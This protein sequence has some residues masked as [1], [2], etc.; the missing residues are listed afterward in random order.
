M[1]LFLLISARLKYGVQHPSLSAEYCDFF[2]SSESLNNI[3]AHSTW[4]YPIQE[5]TCSSVLFSHDIQNLLLRFNQR[6][7]TMF[8]KSKISER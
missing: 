7:H 4:I 5:S 8:L 1:I 3:D 2:T 6:N